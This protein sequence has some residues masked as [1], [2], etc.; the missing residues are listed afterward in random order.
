MNTDNRD[1][2]AVVEVNGT[3]LNES[4]LELFSAARAI[5][6]RT[7]GKITAVLMGH[8]VS[9]FTDEVSSYGADRIILVDEEELSMYKTI[10]YAG[11]LTALIKKYGPDAVIISATKNGKDLAPRVARR[12]GTGITANCTELS[13]DSE[14]GLISWNMPAPGGIMATILCRDTKPQM[15][16]ICPGAF[17]KAKSNAVI[18]SEIIYEHFPEL[19]NDPLSIIR[20]FVREAD[21]ERSITSSDIIVAGGR[22]LGSAENFAR[23]RELA[24]IL[25]AAVGASRAVVDLEWIDAKH[26]IGQTGKIVN[27]RLYIAF[28]ISGALQH[29]VGV[30]HADCIV[31]VN[32]DETAPIMDYADYAVIGDANAV[33]SELIDALS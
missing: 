16:T 17:K 7:S 21:T 6:A 9:R 27:P 30:E 15:G 22:G 13:V 10:P 28:G 1:I 24:D 29:M 11:V 31:A 20:R 23:L 3:S 32:K 25:G 26:L 5:T 18:V 12:L 4:S 19:E 14:S 2:F 33:L 8:D